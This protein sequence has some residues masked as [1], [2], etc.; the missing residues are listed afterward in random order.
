MKRIHYA[1]VICGAAALLLFCNMGICYNLMSVYLP[2]IQANGLSPGIASSLIS[3]RC[4]AGVVAM[5]LLPAF[6]RR[7]SYRVGL[8]LSLVLAALSGLLYAYAQNAPLYY[9]ASVL[10]GL[11]FGFGTMIPVS[12]LLKRWFHQKYGTALGICSTGSGFALI[13]LPPIITKLAD[14]YGL[15]V[16]FLVQAAFLL[17][18]AGIMFLLLRDRPEDLSLTPLGQNGA[19]DS[20]SASLSSHPAAP[21]PLALVLLSILVLGGAGGVI[22]GHFSILFQTSGYSAERS[23]LFLSFFGI[24]MSVSKVILG[25]AADR[26][27]NRISTLGST[28]VMAIGCAMA[29]LLDGSAFLGI[30]F[31][32]VLG[33]GFGVTSVGISLWAAD[34]SSEETYGRT[35]KNLQIALSGGSILISSYPGFLYERTGEYRS[36]YAILFVLSLLTVLLL[37]IAYRLHRRSQ[38]AANLS[39]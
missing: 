36:S 16:T 32:L 28:V 27:G 21:L 15:S 37:L 12:I 18:M 31:T 23:A 13:L 9:A 24:C 7:F 17:L 30:A 26:I 1:W 4:F 3:V 19:E 34:F 6:F 38:A 25:A 29:L 10:S 5:A 20:S 11:A 14:S 33:L 39:L 2:L 35:V 8:S 22:P